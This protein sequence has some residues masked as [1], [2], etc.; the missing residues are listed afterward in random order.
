VRTTPQAFD[1]LDDLIRNRERVVSKDDLVKAIGKGRAVSDAALMT[2]LN[3]ARS[4][5]GDSG[6]EQRLIKT[7]PRRRV[8]LHTIPLSQYPPDSVRAENR[9]GRAGESSV[10]QLVQGLRKAGL[11]E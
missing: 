10:K 5:I 3:A 9:I 7:L 1:L 11:A 2:R 8:F 6:D 4:A